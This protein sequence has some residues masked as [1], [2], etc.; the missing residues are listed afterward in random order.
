[1]SLN[2]LMRVTPDSFET[3]TDQ[4]NISAKNWRVFFI[5]F[6]QQLI[7][8]LIFEEQLSR[9]QGNLSET[10]SL[11]SLVRKYLAFGP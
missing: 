3:R 8:V 6:V 11:S 10:P 1:M 4:K 7:H 9:T 5:L 2:I